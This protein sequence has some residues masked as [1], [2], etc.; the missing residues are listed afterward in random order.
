VVVH[1]CD[2]ALRKLQQEDHKFEASLGYT[3]SS[4]SIWDN[5]ETL[6]QTGGVAQVV[7]LMSSKHKA[8]SSNSNT[9]KK[10]VF[11]Y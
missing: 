11:T 2:P 9:N 3:A 8:L 5:K 4:R 1:A 6:S 7:E 10:F